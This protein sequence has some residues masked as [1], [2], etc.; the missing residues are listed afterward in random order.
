MRQI[1]RGFTMFVGGEDYGYEVEELGITI[2]TETYSEHK[3]GGAVMSTSVPILMME[4]MEPSM[5]MG[6]YNPKLLAFINRPLGTRDTF[7]FRG[8]LVD[9]EDGKTH[10]HLI[11]YEA[12]LASAKPTPWSKDGKS[13]V[14]YA[15]KGVW[16]MKYLINN[17]VMHEVGLK[18]AKLVVNGQDRL[19]EINQ[20]LGR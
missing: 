8:A 3:Y 15:L 2:P 5:K 1:L 10:S 20:A 9:E 11:I 6:A 14:D 13:E 17:E 12:R 19:T 16:Y 4:N 7:T 18:P